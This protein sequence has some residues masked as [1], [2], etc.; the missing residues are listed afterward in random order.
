M[1][2]IFNTYV[3]Y[4]E[5]IWILCEDVAKKKEYIYLD[6]DQD[7]ANVNQPYKTNELLLNLASGVRE[8]LLE[9]SD[10]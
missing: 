5:R 10:H 1:L 6:R 9:T 4:S 8:S 3:H 7:K 2:Y